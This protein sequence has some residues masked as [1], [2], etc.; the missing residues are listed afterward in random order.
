MRWA[1][2]AKNNF[3]VNVLAGFSVSFLVLSL[4]AVFGVI[5][6]RGAFIGMV[7]AV[8]MSLVT[9]IL[10]G[11]KLQATSPTG[12]MTATLVA[13]MA[14]GETTMIEGFSSAQFINFSLIFAG[15]LL[16]LAG[17]LKINRLI[18]Y[19]PNI[20]ISGFMTGVGL[21]IAYKEIKFIFG[22]GGVE[23]VGGP[24]ESN[25]VVVICTL[26]IAFIASLY[27]QKASH[28]Y[29]KYLPPT[30]LV[31]ILSSVAVYVWG[32]NE[33]VELVSIGSGDGEQFAL[34]S[35]L[36]DQIPP[37]I[38]LEVIW[39]ALPLALEIAIIA[40]LDTLMTAM[41]IERMTKEKADHRK[42]LYAQGLATGIIGLIGGIPGAQSTV[43]S[44]MLINEGATKRIAAISVG[45]FT[46]LGLV[47]L[48][49]LIGL[50][51]Q[52]VFI[53]VVIKIA[54]DVS[55]PLPFLLFWKKKGVSLGQIV[56]LTGIILTTIFWSLNVAVIGST[57]IYLLW[58]KISGKPLIKDLKLETQSEGT[59]DEM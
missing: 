9:A 22:F 4:G 13:V 6:G 18:K 56:F 19:V 34:K 32:V 5:S 51:P 40:Y 50:I 25:L 52:A 8:I 30:L 46:L 54:Y 55:D 7:S 20:V 24:L 27:L 3:L 37:F 41:V 26:I 57:V 49:D 23:A 48:R 1:K 43:P 15:V 16:L 35:F 36:A 38:S 21:L 39:K 12:P 45:V 10:S 2:K 47:V 29:W 59:L 14:Q 33:V 28:P 17:I 11:T 42:D 44:V 31:I 53:G 58:P